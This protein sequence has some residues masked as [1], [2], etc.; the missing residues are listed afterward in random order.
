MSTDDQINKTLADLRTTLATMT[1]TV[2]SLQATVTSMEKRLHMV[3][4]VVVL[5]VGVVGGPNAVQAIVG[6]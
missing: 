2:A 5:V 1:T 4:T 6:Q 3:Y